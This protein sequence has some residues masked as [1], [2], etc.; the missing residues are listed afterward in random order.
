MPVQKTITAYTF[1][2]LS[3]EAKQHAREKF[4]DINMEHG[5]WEH[6]YED[7][8]TIAA[9]IGIEIE[10]REHRQRKNYDGGA[11]IQFS[12]FASQGDGASFTGTWTYEEN[13]AA[14]VRDHA[15]LDEKLHAI[16]DE[17]DRL[18]RQFGPN[19]RATIT[20]SHR[21][22]NYV[23]ENMVDIDLED[24]DDEDTS[25][26]T[27]QDK[28]IGEALRSFMTWIYRQLEAEYFAQTNDEAV[29]E[30]I[31]ANEYLFTEAGSRCAAL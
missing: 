16:A 21:G 20:R 25:F 19:W 5:W 31:K 11:D 14:A 30:T 10:R 28:A 22:G 29:D 3:K 9:M 13:G 4:R 6:V 18:G 27:E 26:T 24:T 1:A 2:E 8:D 7:A 17:L 12:G 23:H 15:P